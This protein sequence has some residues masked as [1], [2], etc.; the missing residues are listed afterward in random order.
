MSA[1]KLPAGASCPPGFY[2]LPPSVGK[3]SLGSADSSPS[4]V[5][6]RAPATN[7]FLLV[8]DAFCQ[9]S[10]ALYYSVY[11][12]SL[13]NNSSFIG[14]YNDSPLHTKP[15][16]FFRKKHYL[17]QHNTITTM[18]DMLLLQRKLRNCYVSI[19]YMTTQALTAVVITD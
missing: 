3:G 1:C 9:H 8:S 15:D 4:G 18:H 12:L 13:T 16:I 17:K 6:G 7:E 19:S 14:Y 2:T 5:W 10:D 11:Q